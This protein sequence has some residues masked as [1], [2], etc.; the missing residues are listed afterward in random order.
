MG[1]KLQKF[2]KLMEKL[3]NENKDQ[4]IV[5]LPGKFSHIF[6]RFMFVIFSGMAILP[7]LILLLGGPT[8]HLLLS[9]FGFFMAIQY[10]AKLKQN[11]A[12]VKEQ[13]LNQ[14]NVE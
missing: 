6:N 8:N 1:K 14:S 3:N 4:S 11:K 2:N 13:E 10:R 5:T 9:P 7:I 12:I